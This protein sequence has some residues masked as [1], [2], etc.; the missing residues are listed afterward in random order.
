MAVIVIIVILVNSA[1]LNAQVSYAPIAYTK[2]LN[3]KDTLSLDITRP[4]AECEFEGARQCREFFPQ[5]V[6]P[7]KTVTESYEQCFKDVER[8][9]SQ[10]PRE[11]PGYIR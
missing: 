1:T 9:C 2:V 10:A 5:W 11:V 3:Y 7:G 6:Y 8:I 4:R